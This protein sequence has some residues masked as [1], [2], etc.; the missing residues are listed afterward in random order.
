MD[1]GLLHGVDLLDRARELALERLQVVD[2]VLELRDAELAVIK[3]FEAFLP[4]RQAFRRE[5]QA[6]FVHLVGRHEDRRAEL[7]LLDFVVD[8]LLFEFRCDFASVLRLHVR[9]ERHH[10]RLAA[11]ERCADD[12][13]RED[14]DEAADRDVSLFLAIFM[15]KLQIPVFPSRLFCVFC[16]VCH[17]LNPFA[18]R[19]VC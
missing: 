1:A 11:V 14:G 4:A 7:V 15:P 5:V 8:F 19:V 17:V 16:L 12:D 2:L 6:R 3:D 10:I 18:H 9:E 13:G